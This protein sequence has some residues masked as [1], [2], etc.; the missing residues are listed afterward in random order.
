MPRPVVPPPPT[1][2][3]YTPR[4]PQ[5]KVNIGVA[6]Q[7]VAFSPNGAHLAAGTVTGMVKVLLVENMT[8]KVRGCVG[9]VGGWERGWGWG[10]VGGSKGWLSNHGPSR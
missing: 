3:T 9:W 10:G 6:A 5:A 1:H 8:V 2:T 4:N 7:S